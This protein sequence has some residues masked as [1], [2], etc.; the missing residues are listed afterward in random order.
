[1]K[2]ILLKTMLIAFLM[3]SAKAT[4]FAQSETEFSLAKSDT[5]ASTTDTLSRLLVNSTS[6]SLNDTCKRY[7]LMISCD[8]TIQISSSASFTSNNTFI[9]LPTI[10]ILDWTWFSAFIPNWYWKILGTGTAKVYFKMKGWNI[11]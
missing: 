8:D 7:Q 6:N 3:L 4:L 2:K 1:M 9:L 10:A 11:Q 5:T